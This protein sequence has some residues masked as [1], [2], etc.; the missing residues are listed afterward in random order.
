MG[1]FKIIA[2]ICGIGLVGGAIALFITNPDQEAYKEYAI[3]QLQGQLTEGVCQDVPA[4]LEG[5]CSAAVEKN[6]GLLGTV[7]QSSTTRRN[8]YVLSIYE[9]DID[10]VNALSQVLPGNLSL[11][12]GETQGLPTYHAE[13]VG[14]LGHFVTYKTGKKN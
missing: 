3:T 9:T 2:G 13:T 8:Y 1:G 6:D 12:V 5:V 4:L 11:S 7:V 14:I 10:P